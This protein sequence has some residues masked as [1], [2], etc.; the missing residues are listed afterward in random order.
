MLLPL[1][2]NSPVASLSFFFTVYKFQEIFLNFI[3]LTLFIYMNIYSAWKSWDSS[4]S[5]VLGYRLDDWSSIP[6]R[7]WEFFSS[8][9]HPAHFWSL[10]SLISNWYQGFCPQK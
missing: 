3:I 6:G 10:C 9:L 4:I 8:P 1:F 5:I 7:D 2:W